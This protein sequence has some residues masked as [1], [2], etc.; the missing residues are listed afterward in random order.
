MSTS[1]HVPGDG[2]L[3]FT[4]I[5]NKMKQE[6]SSNSYLCQAPKKQKQGGAELRQ[7]QL[8]LG[9]DFTLNKINQTWMVEMM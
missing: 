9:L 3:S 5:L 8:R 6:T 7:A 1:S 2:L 4:E